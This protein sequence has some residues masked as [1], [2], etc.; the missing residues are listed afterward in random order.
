MPNYSLQQLKQLKCEMMTE[1]IIDPF[2]NFILKLYLQSPKS[3]RRQMVSGNHET[4]S[5]NA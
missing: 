4:L 5:Q 2:P 3:W 1:R